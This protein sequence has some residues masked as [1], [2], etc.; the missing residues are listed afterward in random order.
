[1]SFGLFFDEANCAAAPL[2]PP[3]EGGAM[4]SASPR[5]QTPPGGT[6]RT[7]QKSNGGRFGVTLVSEA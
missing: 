5:T 3:E 1:M 6:P 2:N 7:P 4:E